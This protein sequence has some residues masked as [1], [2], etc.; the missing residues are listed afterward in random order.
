MSIVYTINHTGLQTHPENTTAAAWVHATRN[1][2]DGYAG[3]M[4][5]QPSISRSSCHSCSS[6]STKRDVEHFTNLSPSTD[7]HS[8]DPKRIVRYKDTPP[9]PGVTMSMSKDRKGNHIIT[10]YKGTPFYSDKGDEITQVCT[11]ES[12]RTGCSSGSCSRPSTSQSRSQSSIVQPTIVTPVPSYGTTATP[13]ADTIRS[14]PVIDKLSPICENI[15]V[16]IIG[17][18]VN[19]LAIR[20]SLHATYNNFENVDILPKNFNLDIKMMNNY[21]DLHIHILGYQSCDVIIAHNQ[22]IDGAL[23]LCRGIGYNGS[24]LLIG[25]A[26]FGVIDSTI[27]IPPTISSVILTHG[28]GDGPIISKDDFQTLVGDIRAWPYINDYDTVDE[29]GSLTGPSPSNRDYSAPYMLELV[30][31]LRLSH[32]DVDW[33]NVL[34]RRFE[35]DSNVVLN[36]WE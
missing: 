11:T 8:S 23:T 27:T 10:Y 3:I 30:R 34:Q 4:S 2:V 7:S 17:D 5:A 1:F 36:V 12:R 35:L 29:M 32:L 21:E 6:T 26:T 20:N 14:F 22:W 33:E 25:G 18:P 31:A 28:F 24:M 16:V 9:R 19:A 13:S 15:S